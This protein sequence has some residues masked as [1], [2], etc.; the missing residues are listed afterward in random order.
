MDR[1]A[2]NPT[3]FMAQPREHQRL[4]ERGEL[5]RG[6]SRDAV[7]LAWG[8]PSETYEGT[9]NGD[10]M[11]RWSYLGRRNVY[12]DNLAFGYG[13]GWG[14]PARGAWCYGPG[15]YHNVGFAQQVSQ[16]PYQKAYVIFKNNK[17]DSW[18]RMKLRTPY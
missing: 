11:E 2:R 3:L 7:T 18:E 15:P 14:V 8:A 13:I 10:L 5:A 6:M 12:H 1:I 9:E 17:V 4:I 16:I